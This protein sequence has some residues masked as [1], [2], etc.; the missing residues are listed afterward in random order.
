MSAMATIAVE[1]A[2]APSCGVDG[3]A[4]LTWLVHIQQLPALPQAL[5]AVWQAQ[6]DDRLSL[7]HCVELIEHDPALAGRILRLANA[8]FYG[9]SGQVSNIGDAMRLLGLRTVAAALSAAVLSQALSKL[10]CPGFDLA[11]HWRHAVGTALLARTLAPRVALSADDAFLAGLMHDMG[12]LVLASHA[13]DDTAEILRLASR[14]GWPAC[15][16]ERHV[17]GVDH[18]QVG[19]AVAAHWRFPAR[20]VQAIAQHHAPPAPQGGAGM[21]LAGLIQLAT[22]AADQ[23]ALGPAPD[24]TGCSAEPDTPGDLGLSEPAWQHTLQHTRLSVA[25]WCRG[26]NLGGDGAAAG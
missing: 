3:T 1:P 24:A 7:P 6:R 2:M 9:A 17:L 8:A 11:E 15:Q 10:S 20:I 13:P 19:A 26:L 4:R 5:Q 25:E 23:L 14:M 21:S 16:A 22:T 18:P 12:L